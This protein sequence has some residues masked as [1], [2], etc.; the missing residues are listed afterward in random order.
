ML[1]RRPWTRPGPSPAPGVDQ[2]RCQGDDRARCR[3]PPDLV[4]GQPGPDP[5]LVPGISRP[6]IWLFTWRGR[7]LP[8]SCSPGMATPIIDSRAT[9]DAECLAEP[10]RGHRP[11]AGDPDEAVQRGQQSRTADGPA[12]SLPQGAGRRRRR[13]AVVTTS[14]FTAQAE[15]WARDHN[16]KTIDGED[17]AEMVRRDDRHDLVEAYAKGRT[18][19]SEAGGPE[20]SSNPASGSTTTMSTANSS[21]DVAAEIDANPWFGGVILVNFLFWGGFL[22]T[23]APSLVPSIPDTVAVWTFIGAWLV[24]PLVLFKDAFEQHARDVESAP[25]RLLWAPFALL[26]PFVGLPWYLKRRL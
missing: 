6:G 16:I 20:R 5:S 2:A 21:T 8:A 3:G 19:E 9:I 18:G 26:I 25:N 14:E 12:V 11:D 15:L 22:L 10:I 4:P 7:A 17:L 23:I 13:V 24:S 1:G